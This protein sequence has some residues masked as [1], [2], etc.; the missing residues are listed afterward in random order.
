MLDNLFESMLDRS[1][2]ARDSLFSECT[3][4]IVGG[5]SN[6]RQEPARPATNRKLV[7]DIFSLESDIFVARFIFALAPSVSPRFAAI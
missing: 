2:F 4:A 6:V 1:W 5:D 7:I 3:L